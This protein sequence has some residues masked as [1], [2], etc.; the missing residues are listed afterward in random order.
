MNCPKADWVSS[1]P[2]S[3]RHFL[4]PVGLAVALLLVAC[5]GNLEGEAGRGASPGRAEKSV[6]VESESVAAVPQEEQRPLHDTS[7][8]SPAVTCPS[9]SFDEFLKAFANRVDVQRT[10]TLRPIRVKTPYYWRYNTEPGDPRYPKWLTEESKAKMPN[11]KYRYDVEKAAY[12]WD[13]AKLVAGEPWSSRD[14]SGRARRIAPLPYFKV[15]KV[16]DGRYE[17][18]YIRSGTDSFV[19]KA[20]CWYFG[21]HWER[22]SIVDCKWPDDCRN[23]REWEG[24]LTGKD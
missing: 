14:S 15:R 10:Y 7:K 12:V 3:W 20:G 5:N 22:E 16:S 13:E 11:I 8:S 6:A 9:R 2:D 21:Q 1:V 17:V 19:M 23:E 18:D 4:R 24:E